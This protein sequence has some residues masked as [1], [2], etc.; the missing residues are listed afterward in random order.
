MGLSLAWQI[1]Y[2]S[3][4]CFIKKPRYI[5]FGLSLKGLDIRRYNL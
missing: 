1:L 4:Q 2:G 5:S 3:F